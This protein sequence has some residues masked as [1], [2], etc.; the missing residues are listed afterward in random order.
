M[1]PKRRK[2]AKR[3]RRGEARKT[4]IGTV[5]EIRSKDRRRLRKVAEH[6]A[7]LTAPNPLLADLQWKEA[8]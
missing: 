5:A 1:R 8:P 4:L 6:I 2:K 3:I 7:H